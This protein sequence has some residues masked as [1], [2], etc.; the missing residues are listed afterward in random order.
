MLVPAQAKQEGQSKK[1]TKT[2]PEKSLKSL[3]IKPGQAASGSARHGVAWA[4]GADEH[5]VGVKGMR[6]RGV[7]ECGQRVGAG[8][9]RAGDCVMAAA[10]RT[11]ARVKPTRQRSGREA[12][13]WCRGRGIY[14][15]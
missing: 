11:H 7:M 4:A 8:L 12:A 10:G 9:G 1:T 14:M 2:T 13:P 6:K 15:A 5:A 3:P